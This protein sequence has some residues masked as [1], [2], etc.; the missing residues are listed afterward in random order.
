MYHWIK[1]EIY[2]VKAMAETV[3]GRD[4][5]EASKNKLE[6]KKT[7]TETDADKLQRGQRSMTTIMKK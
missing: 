1:G 7:K 5:L 4:A 2:D 6:S 3:A